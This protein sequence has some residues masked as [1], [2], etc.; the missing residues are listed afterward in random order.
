MR[1]D[2][3]ILNKVLNYL[4]EGVLSLKFK[5]ND[6]E[7]LKYIPVGQSIFGQSTYYYDENDP[8][9]AMSDVFSI[10][11]GQ[12]RKDVLEKIIENYRRL[13]KNDDWGRALIGA[14]AAGHLEIVRFLHEYM[15]KNWNVQSEAIRNHNGTVLQLQ[16]LAEHTFARALLMASAQGRKEVVEYLLRNHNGLLNERDFSQA[17]NRAAGAGHTEVVGWLFGQLPSS[18]ERLSDEVSQVLTRNISQALF[19]AAASVREEVVEMFL[20][21]RLFNEH[22]SLVTETRRIVHERMRQRARALRDDTCGRDDTGGD[23]QYQTYRRI[24]R[25]LAQR[26]QFYTLVLPAI[27]DGRVSDE[28]PGLGTA[29]GLV[30]NELWML[31][32]GYVTHSTHSARS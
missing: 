9:Y 10:A 5:V 19:R 8:L 2:P 3:H 4:F 32:L 21:H 27:Y 11:A 14:A 6:I 23:E 7:Q 30:P 17:L 29:L 13:L 25:I 22:N 15:N 18:F 12:N 1:S 20:E 24:R 28:I 26:Q 31:I 16:R